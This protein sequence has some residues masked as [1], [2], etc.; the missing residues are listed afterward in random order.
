MA[1]KIK[2]LKVGGHQFTVLYVPDSKLGDGDSCGMCDRDTNT[3]YINSNL[4]KSQQEVTLL[5]ELFHAMN[6]ELSEEMLESL[7]QQI[8]QVLNDNRNLF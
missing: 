6:W 8:Y 2:K 3:I 7:S 1:N 5:H 4:A